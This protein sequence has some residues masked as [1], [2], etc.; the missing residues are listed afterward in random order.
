MSR[1]R[2]GALHPR[3]IADDAWLAPTAQVIGNVVVG[4]E[5]SIWF[6]AVVRGD[7]EPIVMG[8]RTNVQDGCVLHTDPG[9][10]LR[11]GQ[12]TSVGRRVVLHG[13]SIGHNCLIGI[14]AV[15]LNHASIGRDSLVAANSLVTERKQFAPRSLIVG[16]P[17][18]VT[19]ELT[20][21]ELEMIAE[22]ASFYVRNA[23]RFQS[24][25]RHDD[26]THRLAG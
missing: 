18:R 25:L 9:A 12:D 23:K 24:E 7:N 19:R 5:A 21:T 1:Y 16:S 10:P 2:L 4:R 8:D 14:G 22:N 17:A 15:I 26:A 13:C 3:M 6:S 11:I 20:D